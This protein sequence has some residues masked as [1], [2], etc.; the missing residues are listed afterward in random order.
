MESVLRA[1]RE[2]K[3]AVILPH[4]QP[5]CDAIGSALAM[6]ALL[7]AFGVPYTICLEEAVPSY[8]QFLGGNFCIWNEDMNVPHTAIAIDCGD[9]GRLTTRFSLFENSAVRVNIDHHISNT[10]FG[11]VNLV[12]PK[13]AATAEIMAELYER[14]SVCPTSQS[15]NWMLAGILTDTGGFRFSN[16]AAKTHRIAAKLMEHGADNTALTRQLFEQ[17]S[18]KKLQLEAAV[19]NSVT[20]AHDG[21]TVVGVISEA[22]LRKLDATKDDAE[23]I[24]SLLRGIA[25]VETAVVLRESADGIR[26]SMRTEESVDASLICGELGGGGHARAAGATLTGES[27]EDWKEKIIVRIGEEYG[28]HC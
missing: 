17:N 23:G 9:A 7:D 5:D 12:Q 2:A 14:A 19:I 11:D 10:S 25:G 28:R 13:A 15:A 21:R 6:G 20:M 8:L 27:I 16:T 22:L 26:L 1:L 18:I 24:S 4:C 3:N